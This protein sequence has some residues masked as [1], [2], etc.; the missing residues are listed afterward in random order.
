M[1]VELV[2]LKEIKFSSLNKQI[3]LQNNYDWESL[4]DS[5]K[6]EGFVPEKY[7]YITIS[8]DGIVLNGHHRY[9]VLKKIYN[10]DYVVKVFRR[11]FNYIPSI[12]FSILF[13]LTIVLPLNL[14]KL[15][16]KNV[17]KYFN[18]YSTNKKK[19]S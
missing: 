6:N 8:K 19:T 13:L 7:G 1:G 16:I 14:I 10:D 11:R 12:F 5:I 18:S 2:K 4:T 15:L 9:V 3:P 17:P